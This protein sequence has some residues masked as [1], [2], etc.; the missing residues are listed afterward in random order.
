MTRI[1]HNFGVVRTCWCE[2]Q[3]RPLPVRGAQTCPMLWWN[4]MEDGRPQLKLQTCCVGGEKG[5]AGGG[6]SVTESDCSDAGTRQADLRYVQHSDT[7]SG[8][9]GSTLLQQASVIAKS[10]CNLA[11]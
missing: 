2:P 5:R 9:S 8:G 6:V 10:Q 11:K 3:T 1:V 4:G 7:F